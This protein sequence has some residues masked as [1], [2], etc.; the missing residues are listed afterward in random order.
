MPAHLQE[1]NY[2]T[3]SQQN[4]SEIADKFILTPANSQRKSFIVL[5][6][7]N[8]A[9]LVSCLP[10]RAMKRTNS[11]WR[12]VGPLSGTGERRFLSSNFL[13]A[14]RCPRP[15]SCAKLL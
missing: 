3:F 6:L 2:K 11:L 15:T 1:V 13:W 8:S 4:T 10:E 7:G 5:S 14:M 12:S 9:I